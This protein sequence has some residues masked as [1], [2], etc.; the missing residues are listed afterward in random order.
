MSDSV[1]LELNKNNILI[2]NFN[3]FSVQIYFN[4][5]V[6]ILLAYVFLIQ[7]H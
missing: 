1:A 7:C 2:F 6:V 3:I 4:K 5:S